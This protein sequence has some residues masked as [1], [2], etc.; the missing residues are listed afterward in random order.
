MDDYLVA[1]DL[2]D[3]IDSDFLATAD[4]TEAIKMDRKAFFLIWSNVS[5]SLIHFLTGDMTASEAWTTLAELYTSNSH[6]RICALIKAV[7]R[8]QLVRGESVNK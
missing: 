7:V 1:K 2:M 8:F 5:D 6:S 4:S 3:A